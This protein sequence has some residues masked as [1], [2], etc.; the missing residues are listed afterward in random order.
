MSHRL[1]LGFDAV[2]DNITPAQVIERIL[3]MVPPPTPVWNNQQ[4]QVAHT[5][6]RYRSEAQFLIAGDRAARIRATAR[7]P[8]RGV[9]GAA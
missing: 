3:A 6:H 4:R 8:R 1:V 2:A 9:L 7:G 5:Q